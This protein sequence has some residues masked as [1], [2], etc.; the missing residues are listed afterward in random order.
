MCTVPAQFLLSGCGAG[1]AEP[2]D[3]QRGARVGADAGA[4]PLGPAP[5]RAR[6]PDGGDAADHAGDGDGPRGLGPQPHRRHVRGHRRQVLRR[7]LAAG[8]P[9]G[10][11]DKC[12]LRF[13][14]N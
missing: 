5:L 12:E 7:H 14:E 6:P 10:K 11:H 1:R 2:A 9:P 8:P 4:L 3:A 13:L